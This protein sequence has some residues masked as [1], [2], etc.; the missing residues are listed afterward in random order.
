MAKPI[1]E[2]FNTLSVE[3]QALVNA[4][5]ADMLTAIRLGE[6]RKQRGLTQT[7][8]ANAMHIKQ[9]TVA[10]MEKRADVQLSTLRNYLQVL[11][12]DLELSAKFPDGTV[13]NLTT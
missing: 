11:G 12:G 6:L 3:D 4:K 1:S 13:V 8:V 5:A 2:L 10:R 9:P 7:Q